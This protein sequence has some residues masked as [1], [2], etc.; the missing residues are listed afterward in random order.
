MHNM[1]G[2]HV[3][4]NSRALKDS[5]ASPAGASA[6]AGAAAKRAARA[7]AGARGATAARATP[8]PAMAP[9]KGLSLDE[10]RE[11]MLALFTETVRRTRAAPRARRAHPAPLRTS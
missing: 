2:N 9:K 8:A 10:K 3:S 6:A 5:A 11:R 4:K 7:R 1:A